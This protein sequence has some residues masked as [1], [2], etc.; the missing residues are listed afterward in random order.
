MNCFWIRND[1]L[2]EKL[3]VE[4]RIVQEILNPKF[5]YRQANFFYRSTGKKWHEIAC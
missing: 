5:L 4:A 1:L 3:G 2:E